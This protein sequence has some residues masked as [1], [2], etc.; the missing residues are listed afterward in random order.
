MGPDGIH[1][2]VLKELANVTAAPLS[3]I[4]QRSWESGEVPA[5]W[6]LA[7]VIPIY[8]KGM[9]EDPGNY[10]PVSLNSVPRKIMLGAIERHLKEN[11]IIRHSQHGF[12]KGKSSLANL[13]SFYDKVTHLV[14]EGKVVDVAFLDFSKAFDAVPHSI[15]LDKLSNWDMSRYTVR[16]VKNWLK[17]RAQRVVL[18]GATSGRQPV[19][20]GVPQGSILGPV[21][22]NIFI[23]DLDAGVEC[24]LSKF[25][26]DTKLGGAVDSLE[27]REALQRV[28]DRLEH[29]AII[30]DMK[31]NKNKCWILHLGQSNAGRKNR[32]GEEWLERGPAERDLGVLVD[33]RL[34]RSQQC[35]LTAK[36]ANCILGCIK[37][38]I[39][40]WSKEFW[41]PQFKKDMKVLECIQRRATKLVKGLEGMSYEE[42]LRTLGLSSLERRWLRGDLIALY[43]FLRRGSGEG[44]A[45]LFSLVSSDWASSLELEGKEAKKLGSLSREGGIDKAIG[46]G[47]LVLSLWRRL[48]S[49]MKERYPFKEDD[50]YCPR[51]WTTM[52]KG[53]QY[54]RE[55]AMLEVIYGDL[56]DER[57][58]KDPDEV[59]CT[60]PTWWKLVRN[61]PSSCAN[62]LAILTWKDGEGPTVDEVDSH[63]REYQESISSSLV[64]AVEKLS[65]KVQ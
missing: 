61:A 44:G 46:K 47:A 12:T 45:D 55:L 20:S 10:R 17:G 24:T 53:I 42:W 23:N 57:L 3:I 40:S 65:R 37:H 6:K 49:A 14:D 26:D 21:L 52:E 27:G 30:S 58:P 5:D 31:F 29:W 1:P 54:L 62:S 32:L 41:A 48:L 4:Y 15:L 25:A 50:V 2:R 43:S 59:Q 28:L 18:N 22:F 56:D 64:S 11:A 38:S 19:T 13:I 35:A 60:R 9:R 39:T 63:L 36:R 51:K 34:N 33:S 8:K 16:W 7:N